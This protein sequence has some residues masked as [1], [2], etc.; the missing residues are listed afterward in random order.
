MELWNSP[1]H[2]PEGRKKMWKMGV[3]PEQNK[4]DGKIGKVTQP[5]A[6]GMLLS[7]IK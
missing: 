2:K 7:Q 4:L 3:V 6:P 5:K 1:N